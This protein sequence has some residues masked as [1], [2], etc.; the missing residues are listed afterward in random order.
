MELLLHFIFGIIDF[1][2]KPLLTIPKSILFSIIM[3]FTKLIVILLEGSFK[4][5]VCKYF[6][7]F[8]NLRA[9]NEGTECCCSVEVNRVTDTILC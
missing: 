5:I 1:S 9:H 7:F 6:H 3:P 8:C 4:S 2:S